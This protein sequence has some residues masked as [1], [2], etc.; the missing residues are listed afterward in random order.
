MTNIIVQS[1]FLFDS[2][3]H[4]QRIL[5]TCTNSL[6]SYCITEQLHQTPQTV[7]CPLDKNV[8]TEIVSINYFKENTNLIKE[9]QESYNIPSN[10]NYEISTEEIDFYNDKSIIMN[11]DKLNDIMNSMNLNA[12]I[13]SI[14]IVIIRNQ[15]I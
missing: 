11:S 4:L 2:N 6:F 9:L 3:N 10:H 14:L 8:Y 7:T 1:K 12:S 5:P 13:M 15:K